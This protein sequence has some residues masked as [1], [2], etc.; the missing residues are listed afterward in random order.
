MDAGQGAL[1][2]VVFVP[3]DGGT[4]ILKG[5]RP[6]N[7]NHFAIGLVGYALTLQIKRF[8]PQ[9]IIW[10]SAIGG[11]VVRFRHATKIACEAIK[12]V[13][14]HVRRDYRGGKY[15]AGSTGLP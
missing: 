2:P 13:T 5:Q 9:P 14:I 4:D 8:D 12:T 1:F 10:H 6:F 7:K 15:L 11:L 3:I